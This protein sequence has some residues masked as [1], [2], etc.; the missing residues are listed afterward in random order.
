MHLFSQPIST[1]TTQSHTPRLVWGWV[2]SKTKLGAGTVKT[3]AD[4]GLELGA[5]LRLDSKAQERTGTCLNDRIG[6]I[7]KGSH[8]Q[9]PG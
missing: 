3:S 2:P 9:G 8:E 4:G 5:S 1:F 6:L 7:C